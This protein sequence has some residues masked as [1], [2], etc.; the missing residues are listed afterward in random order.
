M[1]ISPGRPG[2]IEKW[3]YI[4]GLVFRDL[5]SGHTGVGYF[6]YTLYIY[7]SFS[8]VRNTVKNSGAANIKTVV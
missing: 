4:F 8:T 2:Q 1:T 3:P 5:A 6:I 7:Y